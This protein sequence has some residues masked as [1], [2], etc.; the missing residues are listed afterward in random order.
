M[1]VQITKTFE[2]AAAHYLEHHGGKCQ[3]L[4]GHTY[5]LEV[6]VEGAPQPV[7]PEFS[8]SG[9]IM[10]FGELKKIVNKTIGPKLDH[11]NLNESF[12]TYPTAELLAVQIFET[13]V[14]ELPH[15]VSIAR[16]RLYETSTSY[17]EVIAG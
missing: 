8:G 12:P 5:R 4:H 7:L 13:L 1:R 6:T 11:R 9:M 16:V 14:W 17:A 15:G 2:F 10:D 3:Q